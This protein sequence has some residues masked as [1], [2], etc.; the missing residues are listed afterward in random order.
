MSILG[1]LSL[2]I[3][4]I[5][6]VLGGFAGYILYRDRGK[7]GNLGWYLAAGATATLL[8]AVIL[9]AVAALRKRKGRQMTSRK[10]KKRIEAIEDAE[11]VRRS[12]LMRQR[13]EAER[14]SQDRGDEGRGDYENRDGELRDDCDD[15]CM[16]PRTMR[17][18]EARLRR[19]E[20]KRGGL[21]RRDVESILEEPLEQLVQA[22]VDSRETT[23]AEMNQ[24]RR[25]LRELR[26]SARHGREEPKITEQMV[27]EQVKKASR[28][29]SEKAAETARKEMKR[30]L[31]ELDQR[32]KASESSRREEKA[33]RREEKSQ[34]K[35]DKM[36]E[37]MDG[38]QLLLDGIGRQMAQV[39]PIPSPPHFQ[40]QPRPRMSAAGTPVF[41]GASD[42][43]AFESGRYSQVT[44]IPGAP[45]TSRASAPMS[46]ADR[47]SS[48]WNMPQG[49]ASGFDAYS[50]P[51]TPAGPWAQGSFMSTG[52]STG[53]PGSA[54]SDQSGYQILGN[55]SDMPSYRSSAYEG[56][57][58]SG[59]TVSQLPGYDDAY[60]SNPFTKMS[61]QL[62]GST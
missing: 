15:P 55:V 18:M 45:P 34:R 27:K 8:I 49:D 52:A 24:I 14:R 19:L 16:D 40:Y 26:E 35:V 53:V 11:Q 47:V 39:P 46:D 38:I 48:R 9:M 41:Q 13:M 22:V 2:V 43:S 31:K 42:G 21:N 17:Y 58:E 30:E 36:K 1:I 4:F 6:V 44:P 25:T 32:V 29:A 7:A 3:G 5:G 54:T 10:A 37:R 56:Y 12:Y 60:S 20:Q 23:E 57:E 33:R 50:D 62:T 51:G 61:S 28:E 59:P